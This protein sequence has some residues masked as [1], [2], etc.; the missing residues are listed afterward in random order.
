[1]QTQKALISALL[2][3]A[4]A[5]VVFAIIHKPGDQPA[6]ATVDQRVV[7]TAAAVRIP[8]LQFPDVSTGQEM[9]LN[10]PGYTKTFILLLQGANNRNGLSDEQIAHVQRSY[11]EFVEDRLALEASI[12]KVTSVSDDKTEI[13]IPSYA[14][15]GKALEDGFYQNLSAEL[16]SDLTDKLKGEYGKMIEADNYLVGQEPQELT[17]SVVKPDGLY[18]VHHTIISSTFDRTLIDTFQP[19]NP[20]TYKALMPLFPKI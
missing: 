3:V 5:V 9:D 19:D 20:G 4:A 2:L 12:A 13:E 8:P 18:E 15:A 10:A 7:H 6:L 14:E 11:T 1:M 16:G 17:V